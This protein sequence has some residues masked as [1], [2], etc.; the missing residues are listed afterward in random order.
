M[1]L[2]QQLMQLS[3]MMQRGMFQ[4]VLP[5]LHL[6]LSNN[7]KNTQILRLLA[8]CYLNTNCSDEALKYLLLSLSILDKQPEMHALLAD[9][10]KNKQHNELASKHFQKALDYDKNNANYFTELGFIYNRLKQCRH[11]LSTFDKALKLAPTNLNAQIGKGSSLSNLGEISEAVVLFKKVLDKQPQNYV[12]HYNLALCFKK[13]GDIEQALF[14]FKQC[15]V[16]NKNAVNLY[17]N[18]ASLYVQS[19]DIAKG[20]DCANQGLKL[21]PFDPSLNRF[22]STIQ[23]ELKAHNFLENYQQ[24]AF[25]KMPLALVLDYFYQL[26]KSQA[27]AVAGDVLMRAEI[28]FGHSSDLLVAAS[29][30]NYLLEDFESSYNQLKKVQSQRSLNNSELDWLGRH[31]L[32]LGKFNEARALYHQLVTQDGRNQGY[33]CLYT[34]ALRETD[35]EAYLHLT[36]YNKFVF[37][38]DIDVPDGYSSI[39]AFNQCLM[40]VL[41]K[42][43]VTKQHPLAQS[44]N[45]GTQ[46]LGRIFNHPESELKLLEKTITTALK[47]AVKTISYNKDHPTQQYTKHDFDYTGAW[48]VWLKSAGFHHNHYHSLGWY[49]GVYYISVPQES[50]LTAGAGYLKLGQPDLSLPVVHDAD[51]FVKPTAGQLVLFPSFLWHGTQPFQSAE[52]RVTIAF[53]VAPKI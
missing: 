46:T 41:E 14:H 24:L 37:V 10:Y 6:L 26:I 36:N 51:Y 29:Q 8:F 5:Q 3:T 11:A 47:K 7:P 50:E 49:S 18:I 52:P 22:L 42:Y 2:S 34:T 35:K 25:E 31:C 15:L 32:A 33:W 44:L 43:H 20:I 9:I 19:G 23:W 48:S 30:L 12:S 53:D 1:N 40:T 21:Q 38:L 27:F 45:G 13:E 17:E 4:Q 16:L 39:E 28:K